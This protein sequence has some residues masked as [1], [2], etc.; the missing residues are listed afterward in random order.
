[1]FPLNSINSIIN[2]VLLPTLQRLVAEGKDVELQYQKVENGI[3]LLIIPFA[4][5][6]IL[7]PGFLVRT[8][9]GEDWLEVIPFL[10]YFGTLLLSQAVIY[11]VSLLFLT[12]KK[13]RTVFHIG[14]FNSVALVAAI[15]AGVVFSMELLVLAY[16]LVYLLLIV[17]VFVIAGYKKAFGF[18]TRRLLMQW[19]FRI[20]VS[21]GL[22][23]A[24]WLDQ[25]NWV[26]FLAAAYTVWNAIIGVPY[27]KE[28]FLMIKQR[29]QGTSA[30]AAPK[31]E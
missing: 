9:W 31:E 6:L 30:N 14:I 17:P 29:K 16:T 12:L 18:S 28:I 4:L 25:F 2:Q 26:V 11:P 27:V 5:S 8:I 7:L 19:G 21:L 1:M 3:G 22:V 24:I 10:P 20:G 13:E 23:A 15:W